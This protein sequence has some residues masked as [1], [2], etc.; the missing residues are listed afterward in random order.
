MV[1]TCDFG[2]EGCNQGIGFV[3]GLVKLTQYECPD[4]TS[5]LRYEGDLTYDM[6][7]APGAVLGF[8]VHQDAIDFSDE[9]MTCADTNTGGIFGVDGTSESC[10][11]VDE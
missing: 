2:C 7:T 1:A 9:D 11:L 8:H 4:G 10:G 3:K 5:E 6:T